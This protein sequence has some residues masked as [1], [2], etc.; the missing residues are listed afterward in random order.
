MGKGNN[1]FAWPPVMQAHWGY[2]HVGRV[3]SVRGLDNILISLS[4]TTD[5]RQ[6]GH[7]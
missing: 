5:G 3:S 7:T 1:G 4:S 2:G 6:P